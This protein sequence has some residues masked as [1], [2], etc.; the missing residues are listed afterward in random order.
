MAN[1]NNND[2]NELRTNRQIRLPEVRLIDQDG[3]MVGVVQTFSALKMAEEAGLDL[4]EISPS[5]RPP[6]CKICSYSKL[7][8]Q[9][10]KKAAENK[11]KQKVAGIKEIKL[12]LNIGDGDLQTKLKQTIKFIENGDRVKFNFMF[13]GREITYSENAQLIID[14]VMKSVE[15]IAKIEE[16]PKM[17]GKKLFFTIA[18]IAK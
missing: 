10:Q 1:I 4:V 9:E 2:R 5:V 11:R 3:N 17:E 13:R 7:K 8:Y 6:V 15:T 14:R 18:P 16:K 12:S